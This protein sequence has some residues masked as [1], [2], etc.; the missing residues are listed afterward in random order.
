[1]WLPLV[2]SSQSRMEEEPI[3]HSEAP[4]KGGDSGAPGGVGRWRGTRCPERLS[5][6]LAAPVQRQGL[7]PSSEPWAVDSTV[8]FCSSV[9]PP[10]RLLVSLV[11][12]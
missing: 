10:A 8:C 12:G 1:M 6:R 9:F 7:P 3:I 5:H 4:K 11:G 2:P